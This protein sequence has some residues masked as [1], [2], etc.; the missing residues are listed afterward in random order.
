[1]QKKEHEL[2][3]KIENTEKK[4]REISSKLEQIA[5]L[6][7]EEAKELLLKYTEERYEKDILSLIEKKKKELKNREAEISREILIKSIQ[8][9]A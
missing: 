3:E 8:Q 4:S 6:S 1:M 2:E 9:Y 7:T 5:K